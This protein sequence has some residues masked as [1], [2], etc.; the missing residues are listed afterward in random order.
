MR[1]ARVVRGESRA[2]NELELEGRLARVGLELLAAIEP[3]GKAVA[4]WRRTR[5]SPAELLNLIVQM[6]SLLRAGVPLLDVLADLRDSGVTPAARRVA[7]DILDRIETGSS[8]SD[9]HGCATFDI[10]CAAGGPCAHRRSHR[11][12]AGC[13][14]GDRRKPEMATGPHV[15][16]PQGSALSTLRGCRA[17]GRDRAS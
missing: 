7:A 1:G 2:D 9:A 13:A 8:L 4:S 10:Q 17:G 3:K 6:E 16:N 12:V 5:L 14:G 11:Q 15:Q